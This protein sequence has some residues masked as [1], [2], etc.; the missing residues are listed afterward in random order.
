VHLNRDGRCVSGEQQGVEQ[1]Q[2]D[3]SEKGHEVSYLHAGRSGIIIRGGRT[4]KAAKQK[5]VTIKEKFSRWGIDAKEIEERAVGG[6]VGQQERKE[7]TRTLAKT[8]KEEGRLLSE[9]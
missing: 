7:G 2:E 6:G 4:V 9:G 3:T 5:H 8:G 1:H